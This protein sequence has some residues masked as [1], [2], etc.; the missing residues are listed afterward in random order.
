MDEAGE[1]RQKWKE[2]AGMEG[3][4]GRVEVGWRRGPAG[5]GRLLALE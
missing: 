2:N 1:T 5:I 3:R 4:P